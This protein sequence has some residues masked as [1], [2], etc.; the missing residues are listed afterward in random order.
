MPF[1]EDGRCLI[2][3]WD[4]SVCIN[5]MVQGKEFPDSLSHCLVAHNLGVLWQN[6]QASVLMLVQILW[7][8]SSLTAKAP[9]GLVLYIQPVRNLEITQCGLYYPWPKNIRIWKG[10]WVSPK[11]LLYWKL[12]TLS[13]VRGYLYLVISRGGYSGRY[14]ASSFHCSLFSVSV[15]SHWDFG[16]FVTKLY[17]S[18]SWLLHRIFCLKYPDD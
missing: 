10:S 11:S 14:G 16:P 8:I 13:L 18:C 15:A 12:S 7:N 5:R 3:Q 9:L 17:H 2:I 6:D 4:D 1:G